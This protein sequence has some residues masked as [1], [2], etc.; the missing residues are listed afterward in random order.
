MSISHN[1]FKSD[2]LIRKT[3]A[4]AI[5]RINWQA[6]FLLETDTSSRLFAETRSIGAGLRRD[7]PCK[8]FGTVSATRTHIFE[9]HLRLALVQRS[10]CFPYYLLRERSR[11]NDTRN[12]RR[13]STERRHV[14]LQPRWPTFC[15]KLTSR[16]ADD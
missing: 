6:G 16:N 11:G 13:L 12:H 9:D 8:L 2:R 4:A 7:Q 3:T 14:A 10:P 1:N 15:G 5:T